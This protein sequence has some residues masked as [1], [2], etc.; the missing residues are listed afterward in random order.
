MDLDDLR[1]EYESIGLDEADVD[2][3][4]IAQFRVWYEEA[5]QAGVYEGPAMTVSTVDAGGRPTSRYVLLRGLDERGFTFYTNHDSDKARDMAANPQVALTFGWLELHRQVR[6]NGLAERLPNEDGTR[7]FSKRPEGSRLGAWASPQ[8]RVLSGREE[9]ERAVAE[10]AERFEGG[11]IPK[12]P[13][14]GGWLVRPDAIEFWQGRRDRLHDRLRYRREAE[15]W[16][17]ERLAP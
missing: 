16:T 2:P 17:I 3:D 7:Y 15:R 6:I 4:P 1:R 11:E 8:S 13:F 5:K 10:I 14:W 12:P 9:L